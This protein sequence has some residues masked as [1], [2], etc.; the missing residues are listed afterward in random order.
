MKRREALKSV[1]GAATGIV[2]LRNT[3]GTVE[4]K[5]GDGSESHEPSFSSVEKLIS[6]I[7]QH[8]NL[9]ETLEEKGFLAS[10]EPRDLTPVENF[11][12]SSDRNEGISTA[13]TTDSK[14]GMKTGWVRIYEKY[15]EFTTNIYILT[16][17]GRSYS[18]IDY[19][20]GEDK[21][22]SLD[23]Y[24]DSVEA[25]STDQTSDGVSIQ[26]TINC[27]DGWDHVGTEK[28]CTNEICDQGETT[29]CYTLWCS[30][31]YYVEKT[32]DV[33][34]CL[35]YSD[36]NETRYTNTRRE[37]KYAVCNGNN[38]CDNEGPGC[39]CGASGCP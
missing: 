28:Q 34:E 33:F 37:L 15:D 5:D 32:Y 8:E 19:D 6:T 9:L 4:A 18:I 38:C 7:S 11:D 3:T 13:E 17:A 22:I 30:Y 2:G 10:S 27:D 35:E 24:V 23:N 36:N 12:P 25:H 16:D 31:T 21:L 20:K 1:T 39:G 14:V 26:S 29:N